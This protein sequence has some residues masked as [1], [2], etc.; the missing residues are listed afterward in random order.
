ME[1][2]VK[3][4]FEELKPGGK[5]VIRDFAKPSLTGPIYMKILSTVGIDTVPEGVES[6]ALDYNIL[7]A[8][9]LFERF[10]KEFKQG[11]KNPAFSYERVTRPDGEYLKIEPEWAHEFYLRKDYTANWRQEIKEKYTYWTKEQAMEI[12][13]NAGYEDVQ[14]HEDPN[15]Y[16]LNNRLKGKIA[17]FREGENGLE[18][19]EFPATHMV[20]VG[21]KPKAAD[22]AEPAPSQMIMGVDYGKILADIHYDGEK[23][24]VKIG[25]KQFT[26]EA[27]PL[28]G[29]KKRIFSLKDQPNHVLKVVR[30]DTNNHHSAFKSIYQVAL[31]QKILEQAEVPHLKVTEQGP[32]QKPPYSYLIQEKAPEGSISAAQLVEEGS[33]TE[34]D[35]RQMCEIINSFELGKQ[36]QVDTNPFS[37]FRVTKN[38]GTTQMVYASGKVYHYDENW[39]FRKVG[40]LQWLDPSYVKSAKDFSA[41]I[42]RTKDYQ[43]LKEKIWKQE[44][45]FEPWKKYL[46]S[47][48]LP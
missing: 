22:M 31:R 36:W 3:S 26:V 4:T 8:K 46:H 14:V 19:M 12:M 48:L 20:V 1:E 47:S 43:E 2:A 29:T 23:G 10:H 45:R 24:T 28:T 32:E 7:S 27:Q 41:A 17:L 34:E 44:G 33:L 11:D 39:E 30:E 40:L 5:L 6:K 25:E 37:W 42:P 21:Q 35:I 38:D 15:E 13:K 18:P 9:A 16:I